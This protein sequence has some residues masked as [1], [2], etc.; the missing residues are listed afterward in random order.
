MVGMVEQTGGYIFSIREKNYSLSNQV[1]NSPLCVKLSGNKYN[2]IKK[3]FFLS[4]P[5]RTRKKEQICLVLIFGIGSHTTFCYA[6]KK[7]ISKILCL[8]ST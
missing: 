7:T 2:Y 3:H 1:H 6:L 4:L 8:L 5:R